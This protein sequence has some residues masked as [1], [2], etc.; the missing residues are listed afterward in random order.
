MN[1]APLFVT[2]THSLIW[3]FDASPKLGVSARATFEK[4]VRGEANLIVPT[5]VIAELLFAREKRRIFFGCRCG[6]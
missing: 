6:T 4:V 3:Y 2:D 1:E 5:I